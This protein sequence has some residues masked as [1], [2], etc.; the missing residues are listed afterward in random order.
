MTITLIG[1]SG[2]GK[3]AVAER[4]A[5]ALGSRAID[6]DKIIEFAENEILEHTLARL[7]EENFLKLE[8]KTAR[9]LIFVENNVI[10]TGGSIVLSADAM[11]FLKEKTTIVYLFASFETIEHRIGAGDHRGIVGLARKTLREIYDE[12]LPLYEKYAD[13]TV[14]TNSDT[15]ADVV[16]RVQPALTAHSP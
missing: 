16:Q 1:T 3:S 4:L 11:D 9:E 10:S 12:R 15:T 6:I 2:A 13:V 7:G 5:L 14:D 8:S